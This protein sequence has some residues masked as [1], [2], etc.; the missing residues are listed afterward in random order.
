MNKKSKLSAYP[1]EKILSVDIT[2]LPR[3]NILRI[4]T[5]RASQKKRT[6]I[7][8]PNPQ[9]LLS[10][11][12]SRREAALLRSSDIS[13]PD[14]TGVVIAS[15]LTGGKIKARIGG[16]DLA[17]DI[18]ALAQ[19]K[20]YKVFLLGSQKGV[21]E[22]AK[23][24]LKKKYPMLDICGTHHGYFDKFGE[25]NEKIIKL[26][27]KSRPDIIFVC[28]GYPTQEEWII[29]SKDKLT[30]VRIFIGLGGSL[31]V[32]AQK[33]KRA[34]RPLQAI[35]LEWLYRTVKEPKRARIFLDIPRFLLE[36]WKSRKLKVEN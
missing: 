30:S 4:L 35:G 17:E 29:Q 8:T 11:Q 3:R 22:K 15:K 20:H 36:V 12:K 21:A 18:L 32:W 33:T 34:P 24:E 26:I 6:V 25:E 19:E 10:A 31:D 28:M 13:I 2:T 1:S 9:M 5:L 27:N 16:I 23:K 14:G 7:F